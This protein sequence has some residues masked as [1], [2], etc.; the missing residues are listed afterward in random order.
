MCISL[1]LSK[2]F[3]STSWRAIQITL[4][5]MRFC[6]PFIKLIMNCVSTSSFSLLIESEATNRF[7]S[8]CGLHQGDP[9]LLL[10]LNLLKENLS[11]GLLLVERM[12]SKIVRKLGVLNPLAISYL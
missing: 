2:A 12:G 3:N 4:K 6:D 8:E 7:Y 5:S 9:L 1:D 10:L 11:Q